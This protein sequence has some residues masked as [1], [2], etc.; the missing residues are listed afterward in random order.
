MTLSP[1][2]VDI[3]EDRV[4]ELTD[5]ARSHAGEDSKRAAALFSKAA[6]FHEKLADAKDSPVV[7]QAHENKADSLRTNARQELSAA[8][9]H[10]KDDSA[11]EGNSDTESGVTEAGSAALADAEL[12]EAEAVADVAEFFEEPPA[13]VLEDIG[14]LEAELD[15]IRDGLLKPLKRPEIYDAVG[16]NMS[17]GVL[18]YGPPGTGKSLI[19]RAVANSLGYP[20]AG[21]S[22]AELGSE[23]VNKGAQNVQRL[24]EGARQLQPCVVFIDELDSLARSRSGETDQTDGTRQMI[25][26]LLQELDRIEG[27]EICVIGA[28]NLVEDIDGAIRRSGR[29]DRKIHIGAPDAEDRREIFEI[30]LNDKRIDGSLNWEE[31]IEWTDGFSG[32]DIATVVRQAGQAASSDAIDNGIRDPEQVSGITH[33]QLMDQIKEKDPG[34]KKWEKQHGNRL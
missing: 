3:I 27:T 22:A 6:D 23:Y 21:V 16:V 19:A 24:F 30:H 18:L 11:A 33:E 7:T 4:E 5:E 17:N 13:T 31:L 29:F 20:Y 32:A 28:T 25:T 10:P 12:E 9:I 34:V 8:G 15:R 14:G 1:E 2:S 26:Q